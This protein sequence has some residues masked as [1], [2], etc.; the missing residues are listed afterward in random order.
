MG[1]KLSGMER[2]RS[3]S[4][5][6]L[7]ERLD[8][9]KLMGVAEGDIVIASDFVELSKVIGAGPSAKTG[10]QEDNGHGGML[11]KYASKSMGLSQRRGHVCVLF[12]GG[13]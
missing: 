12:P 9:I 13:G 5:I 8:D 3:N 7:W 2:W 6:R 4:S 1:I 11:L 10:I